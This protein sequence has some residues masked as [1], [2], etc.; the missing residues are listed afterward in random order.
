MLSGI[1]IDSLEVF[2]RQ[3]EEDRRKQEEDYRLD[4]A[5]IERLQRRF[6]DAANIVPGN[7]I[8]MPITSNPI[9]SN[10]GTNNIVPTNV[11]PTNVISSSS[12]PARN[13]P[14]GFDSSLNA[15]PS[16]EWRTEQRPSMFQ[17]SGTV[18]PQDDDLAETPR[19]MYGTSRR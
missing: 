3:L 4:V 9:P 5:A 12:I 7:T 16:S 1:D 11:V 19:S 17:S 2:R 18:M 13:A 14:N 6:L 15:G 8:P 10:S